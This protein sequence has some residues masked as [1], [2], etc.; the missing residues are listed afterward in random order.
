MES[1]DVAHCYICKTYKPKTEFYVNK[2]RHSGVSSN[3]K[4]C[5]KIKHKLYY[6]YVPK[7]RK[8]KSKEELLQSAR[9]RNRRFEKNN[10]QRRL[11]QRL[12][13]RLKKTLL[14]HIGSVKLGR[15]I[16]WLGCSG[17]ELIKHLES[18]WK[19]GM[20]WD[21][22]GWG[23]GKWVIDHKRPI[24]DF[25]RKCEDPKL[26]NHYTNLQALWYEENTEKRDKV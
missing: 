3:C 11:T 22:Y 14:R 25:I 15:S 18:T 12:R 19:A 20:S 16:D 7:I 5:N 4:A 21:N 10:K 1:K 26:A 24:I 17:F 9:E 13:G 6:N 8:K 2:S 23:P